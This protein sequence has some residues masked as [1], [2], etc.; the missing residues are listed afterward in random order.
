[1]QA[2]CKL[3]QLMDRNPKAEGTLGNIQEQLSG[4]L[5]NN[6]PGKDEPPGVYGL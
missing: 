4:G 1:M 2:T 3:G 5:K 6:P